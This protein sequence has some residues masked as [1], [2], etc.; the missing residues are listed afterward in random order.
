[1]G[2]ID[3]TI[4]DQY[5]E[6]E[7]YGDKTYQHAVDKWSEIKSVGEKENIYKVLGVSITQKPISVENSLDHPNLIREVGLNEPF[8]IAWVE[9]N[10]THFERYRFTESNLHENGIKFIQLFETKEEALEWLLKD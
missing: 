10:K 8:K 2:Q 9:L 7:S 4:N 5:I 3:I 1:M 6:V